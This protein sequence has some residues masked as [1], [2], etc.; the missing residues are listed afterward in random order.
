MHDEG[1]RVKWRLAILTKLIAGGDGDPCSRNRTSTG[2]TK[3]DCQT[4]PP[5]SK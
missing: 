5:R 1:P 2:T 4:L 3:T